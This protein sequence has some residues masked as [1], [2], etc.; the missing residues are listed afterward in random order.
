MGHRF[1]ASIKLPASGTQGVSTNP[2]SVAFTCGSTATLLV[3]G[4]GAYGN[5]A[6][7][8]RPAGVPTFSGALMTNVNA[9][10]GGGLALGEMPV[11]MY[12]LASPSTGVSYIISVPNTGAAIG[13]IL[14]GSS[15]CASV[16][17]ASV[18]DSSTW[19]SPV[20][21]QLKNPS[22][23]V[24]T[25]VINEVVVQIVSN[26]ISTP[27][28]VPYPGQNI[29]DSTDKGASQVEMEWYVVPTATNTSIGWNFAASP[30]GMVT[31]WWKESLAAPNPPQ[32]VCPSSG[33]LVNP[34]DGSTF[35]WIS[36]GAKATTYNLQVGTGSTFTKNDI[37]VNV[38]DNNFYKAIDKLY[39]GSCY[40][41]RVSATG[42]G[43]T[44][45]YS[46]T[47]NFIKGTIP[48]TF[49]ASIAYPTT[50]FAGPPTTVNFTP[51][52][53]A[54]LLVVGV[55]CASAAERWVT[56]PTVT[57]GGAALTQINTF[58]SAAAAPEAAIQLWYLLNPS[59]GTSYPVT[60]AGGDA[61][62]HLTVASFSPSTGYGF[63]FNSSIRASGTSINP[64]ATI[65]A[66]W[67]NVVIG[68]MY[69]GIAT[70]PTAAET[71]PGVICASGNNFGAYGSTMQYYLPPNTF[72]GN[73]SLWYNLASDNWGVINANFQQTPGTP[74][75][76][77]LITPANNA[78]G[79]AIN[80]TLVYSASTAGVLPTSYGIQV[81]SSSS[82]ITNDIS[83]S[84][85]A[86]TSYAI[87]PNL[88]NSSDYW[89]RINAAG[90]GG[91]SGFTSSWKFTT[92]A[93]TTTSIK[94]VSNVAYASIKSV[95]AIAI[96]S[97]SKIGGLA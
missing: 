60:L 46:A 97:I 90:E 71:K 29:T 67:G 2:V 31:G 80:G 42:P 73:V 77:Q 50:T 66:S 56:T 49:D 34:T 11:E 87:T 14:F 15:Y 3:L 44:S 64:T 5:T 86:T 93:V 20:T 52:T 33:T 10:A 45:A 36:S 85:I 35:T 6:H 13:L 76:P 1:D 23:N 39:D 65:N 82:F 63:I 95:D 75:T 72:V 22:T 8:G 43:G 96:A 92:A 94:S 16:G 84:K 53:G 12:A 78:T 51:G 26:G 83:V 28:L 27:T 47:S 48:A 57:Y 55:T 17:Y 7:A 30:G 19:Q 41:W 79:F 40:F 68:M 91:I 89:W 59:T 74:I 32:L 54:G 38:T 69:T 81:C 62:T 4:I 9:S 70:P 61:S 24:L 25:T 18:L 37:S 88:I 21:T 58:Q